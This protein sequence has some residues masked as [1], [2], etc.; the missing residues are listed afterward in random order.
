MGS[1]LF[2]P[3]ILQPTRISDKSKT[4]ID[5]IFTNNLEY[6]T[7]SGNLT[8]AIS[9]HLVQFLLIKQFKTLTKLPINN[10][11][12]RDF[13]NFN[14]NNF[15]EEIRSYN[16]SQFLRSD[17]INTVFNSFYTKLNEIL[18]K[19]APL[20]KLTKKE[21][22][23]KEKPWIDKDIKKMM[24][25]R[26]KY[27]KKF[28]RE[29][30]ENRKN[31][32]R[33]IYK[34]LRN[35]VIFL[36]NKSKR[37][38]YESF[39]ERH[40]SDTSQIW[41][42]IKSIVTLKSKCQYKPTTLN[43]NDNTISEPLDIAN[44]F[45]EFFTRIGPSLSE[46]IPKSNQPF[47]SFLR[48]R[49]LESFFLNPTNTDEI[50]KILRNLNKNKA[51]G[52]NSFPISILKEN[53]EILA[54]PIAIILNLSFQSGVFPDK[55]KI[56]KVIPVYKKG[57]M[58]SS[59]N[60]R[61][62]S[63]LSIFS[64]IFEKCVHKRL[65]SFLLKFN[66]L[67]KK[68][69]GF[70]PKYSTEHAL[71]SLIEHIKNKLDNNDYVCG[72]FIDLQK[73]FD[74]VDHEILLNKLS[75]YGI[76]GIANDWFRSFLTDRQQFVN[77][78]GQ[79][80]KYKKITCGVPQG[81]TLG[82]LLFLIYINDLHNAFDKC[83]IHH[84][85]DDTNLI[86]DNKKIEVIEEV[87]NN[88]L[89]FLVEWLRANKLSL[90]ESKTELIL[91]RPMHKKSQYLNV[92]LNNFVLKPCKSVVY[93][94]VTIDEVLSWNKQIEILCSKLSRTIGILSKLRYYV[95]HKT[96]ITIY[97]SL[98]QSY[99]L[100]G[101]LCW[102]FTAQY[103]IDKIFLLQKK[104]IRLISFAK[105]YDHTD[106]LFKSLNIMKVKDI[107]MLQVI[108]FMYQ[109]RNDSLPDSLNS[110]FRSVRTVHLYN[111]RFP[112]SFYVPQ[113]ESTRYG[114]LSLRYKGPSSFN[115]LLRN[116]DILND[117]ISVNIL[118]IAFKKYVLNSY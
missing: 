18:D 44:A 29:R 80:S 27:Y 22:S 113:V 72:V 118:K 97:Y 87:M 66:I 31:D 116:T 76:R 108:K 35:E 82:P 43:F 17:N 39:F 25:E 111:T 89:K 47:Q 15:S 107:F 81:S 30:D 102:S 106:P 57:D 112:N 117:S 63:L 90:N 36:I 86:F 51:T 83:L 100:Y 79:N 26:D 59:S 45:N 7:K 92:R 13:R 70:R 21:I 93:L 53:I 12:E 19:Y 61:P 8:S 20:R 14:H 78:L 74:T 55:L 104:C 109:F 65:Y 4:L 11:F 115:N 105:Y 99:I 85:A 16:W 98:F 28:C 54:E 71:V 62:I 110:L 3:H 34:S 50:T 88:E 69:F 84:F 91:F 40:K 10:R 24:H 94:G 64:K 68:Q 49:T 1:H 56:A 60:Y 52:P 77:V 58:T 6:V 114:H 41:K 67:Y 38:Y 33:S 32:F 96:C 48:N 101:C 75:Y 37:N 9:D 42:G 23:F 46:T 73:A 5:N 2:I 103:N 95:P